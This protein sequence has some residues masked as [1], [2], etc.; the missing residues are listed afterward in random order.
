MTYQLGGGKS[1][2]IRRSGP[3]PT[4][5]DK[6]STSALIQDRLDYSFSPSSHLFSSSPRETLGLV[7]KW[8]DEV[9][10]LYD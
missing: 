9:P 5:S 4:K 7:P 2:Q 1:V 3:P 10:S 6:E 8:T